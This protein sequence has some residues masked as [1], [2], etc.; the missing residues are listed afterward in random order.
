MTH[1]ED[2]KNKLKETLLAMASH[3]ESAVARAIRAL[4]E[5]DDSLAA[6][7]DEDDNILDQFEIEVDDL[8]IHLLAKAPL[9]T[10]LRSITVAMKI[11]QNLE[12]VGDEAVSIA[13][14][15][16]ELNREPQ[17][18]PYVDLPR[19]AAM[20]LEM[21]RDAIT[22]FIERQPEKARAVVPRDQAVDELN[23][24]LYRELSS[25]MIERPAT[26]SRCLGL[27]AVSK[28]LERIADHATNIAE[29][30]VYLYE[31]RDIRHTGLKANE[32]E[33]PAR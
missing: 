31:A 14:R 17:L 7:V 1:F 5:R 33:N 13:R 27:M 4:V 23:R 3:A 9:A 25:F 21:L 12:R 26:I 20:S 28:R 19:M 30:I 22:A 15:V 10:D 16:V 6:Q 29:E 18:K 2:E 11:S 8:A 24:Q 32:I